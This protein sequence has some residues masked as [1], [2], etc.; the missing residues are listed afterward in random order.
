MHVHLEGTFELADLLE[1][2]KESKVALPG[3]AATLFDIDT[4]FAESAGHP[5]AREPAPPA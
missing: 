2:A 3:P 5:G 1:L 4:H